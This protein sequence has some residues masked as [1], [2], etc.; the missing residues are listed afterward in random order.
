MELYFSYF[1][2]RLQ[3]V[4][5]SYG[6][7]SFSK[8]LVR[9]TPVERKDGEPVADNNL[10]VEDLYEPHFELMC[11]N[12]DCSVGYRCSEVGE[13]YQNKWF[14]YVYNDA[15]VFSK[16]ESVKLRKSGIVI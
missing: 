12:C 5:F 16:N 1:Y 8:L 10:P 7:V 4:T 13:G 6:R 3:C 15:V 2:T 11:P 14:T 9:V